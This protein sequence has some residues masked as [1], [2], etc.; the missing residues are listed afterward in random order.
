MQFHY[1]KSCIRSFRGGTSVLHI[2]ESEDKTRFQLIESFLLFPLMGTEEMFIQY[3]L[4]HATSSTFCASVL[5]Y[6]TI[7]L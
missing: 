7:F 2:L 6:A 1:G 3:I 4:L 5:T